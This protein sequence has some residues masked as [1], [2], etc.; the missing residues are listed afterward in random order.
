MK[1]FYGRC[2]KDE[3]IQKNSIDTQIKMVEDKYGKCDEYITD[4]GISG[5]KGIEK[6][7]GLQN[8]LAS[9]SKGDVIY[10]SKM[11]RI[12]RDINLMGYIQMKLNGKGVSLVSV[13]DGNVNEDDPM[14]NLMRNIVNIFSEF[15]RQTLRMR[16]RQTMELKKSRNERVSRFPQYGKKFDGNKLVDD[17]YDMIILE[18]IKKM[19]NEG[20]KITAV[21]KVLDGKGYKSKT[22]LSSIPYMSVRKMYHEV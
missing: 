17:D 13:G 4:K 19:K 20:M 5:S 22:G 1:W 16:I 10:V 2:S 9:T 8:L 7:E 14:S 12:S 6:R 18:E 15:E 21:K 3:E 11:D